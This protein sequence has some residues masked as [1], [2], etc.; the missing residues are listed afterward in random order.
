MWTSS[1]WLQFC[2]SFRM[3]RL[4]NRP[5]FIFF[6]SPPLLN[7]KSK[8][9]GQIYDHLPCSVRRADN[10]VTGGRGKSRLQQ[11]SWCWSRNWMFPMVATFIFSSLF[12][13]TCKTWEYPKP[14]DHRAE[15]QGDNLLSTQHFLHCPQSST[16]GKRWNTLHLKQSTAEKKTP[17]ALP[18]V[19]NKKWSEG[20]RQKKYKR[21]II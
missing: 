9:P 5:C 12:P 16:T 18:S 14:T 8:T 19:E 2:E 10:F 15:Y 20:K 3:G 6:F 4:Q 21:F 11:K 7:L 1:N 17:W 13:Y